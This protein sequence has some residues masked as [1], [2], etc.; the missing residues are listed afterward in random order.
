ML[1]AGASAHV[2][3]MVCPAGWTGGPGD[4][5]MRRL[6]PES[7]MGCAAA[8][9]KVGGALACIQ[10]SLD[11]KLASM[12]EPPGLAPSYAWVGEYQWPIEPDLSFTLQC[13]PNCYAN[14]FMGIPYNGQPSWGTCTN[15]QTTSFTPSRLEIGQP[16]NYHAG[17]DCMARSLVGY[18]DDVCTRKLPCLCELGGSTTAAYKTKH[19][20]A[21]TQRADEAAALLYGNWWRTMLLAGFVGS[22]PALS[23]VLYIEVYLVRWRQRTRPTSAAEASM[24]ATVR[25][26]LRR[27]MLQAG[28]SLWVGGVLFA[29]GTPSASMFANGQWP[30]FGCCDWPLGLPILWTM[31]R[32]PGTLL[33]VLSI[34]PSETIAIRLVSGAWVVYV[35][36]RWLAFEGSAPPWRIAPWPQWATTLIVTLRVIGVAL[37]LVPALPAAP[38]VPFLRRRALPGRLALR[39]LWYCSKPP[40]PQIVWAATVP[41]VPFPWTPWAYLGPTLDS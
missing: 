9:G 1:V 24:Q 33:I 14:A 18:S 26:A 7:H 36:I 39:W 25:L 37:A 5:C 32:H 22:L 4:K 28:T 12:L 2:M 34:L 35:L 15:G 41:S 17:E 8:C 16:N 19:S 10:S 6:P 29:L 20:P 30:A 38:G 3:A 40:C 13:A 27:R 31:L 23:V 21:L 11:D